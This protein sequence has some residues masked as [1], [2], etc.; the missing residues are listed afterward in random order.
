MTAG[1]VVVVAGAAG[2]AGPAVCQALADAGA[3]VIACG[4]DADRLAAVAGPAE[5]HAVDLLDDAATARFAASVAERHGRVDGLVHLVGGWR[6]G[7]PFTAEDPA[8]WTW[9]SDRI[10][11]TLQHTTRAFHPHLTASDAGRL[12]IV[13]AAE[14]T[15]PTANNAHYAAAKAAAEAWTLAVAQS[16]T[17]GPAAA[18]ILVVRG[19]LTDAMRAARPDAKFTSLTH[20]DAVA[21]RIASLWSEPAADLNGARLWLTP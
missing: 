11:R 7:T 10:V 12:A 14:A 8:D 13:S 3:V 9:L 4:R 17:G 20:V 2:A 19:L 6:G 15:R 18:S 5:R 21:G 1:R 16:W